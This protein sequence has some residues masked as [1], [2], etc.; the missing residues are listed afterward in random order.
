MNGGKK[1]KTCERPRNFIFRKGENGFW[2]NLEKEYASLV[3]FF[4][5]I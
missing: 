1:G 4:S 5:Y 3:Y 2:C